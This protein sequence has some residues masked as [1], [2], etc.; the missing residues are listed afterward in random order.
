MKKA[1]D[2]I[3]VYR[4]CNDAVKW[5]GKRTVEQMVNECERGDWLLWLA[6]RAGLDLQPLTLAK[7]RCA[8]TVIHLMKDERSIKAVEV[9]ERFGLGEATREELAA[10]A[11]EAADAAADAWEDDY[12]AY[13]DA[14]VADAA[15]VVA[16]AA[17]ADAYTAADAAADA[18]DDAR[19]ENQMQTA[20]ICREVFGEWLINE[21]NK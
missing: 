3:K 12:T 5:L 9:A 1:I 20:N 10:A 7:A 15:Y 19:K 13:A 18:V 16:D 8:K 4:P 6:Q 11:D 17:Y 14:V 2:V 21:L